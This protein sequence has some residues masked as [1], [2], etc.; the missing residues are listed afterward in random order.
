MITKH[1]KFTNAD[2]IHRSKVRMAYNTPE[3]RAELVR[4]LTD[5]GTFRE[6]SPQELE[7]RNYGVRKLEELG[8]YDIE[9]IPLMFDWLF[10]QPVALRPTV[11][12]M[13]EH[14]DTPEGEE[15]DF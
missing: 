14:F 1:T 9:I 6:I 7:L 11:E 8:F 12:E 2:M 5:L 15:G 13:A 3:G 4:L 10:S